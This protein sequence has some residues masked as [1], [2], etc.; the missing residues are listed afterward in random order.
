M[1][2]FKLSIVALAVAG[3]TACSLEGDDG[4]D[5]AAGVDGSNGLNSLTV[6]TA[7]AVGDAN[8]PN[9]GVQ[10]DSGLDTNADGTLG[11]DEITDTSYVCSPGSSEVAT[12]ELLTTLN[13]DWFIAASAEVENNKQVWMDATG[14]SASI[15]YANIE[16]AQVAND[17]ELQAMVA[18]LRGK[19]KNVILFVGDGMGISTIIE[20][21]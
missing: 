2:L 15:S 6:Q 17:E 19:A 11:S 14:T 4:N 3:L 7:L 1:K 21:V 20:R 8:C 10:F 18:D 5:G 9:S 13:N 16:V 12:G